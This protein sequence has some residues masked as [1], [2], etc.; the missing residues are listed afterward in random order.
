MEEKLREILNS[1][2][3]SGKVN[4]NYVKDSDIQGKLGF[5][6]NDEDR[7]VA[8]ISLVAELE[9]LGIEV[10]S[11]DVGYY[12]SDITKNYLSEIGKYNV[13]T[14]EEEY[15]LAVRMREGDE[16]ALQEL[17][18]H[19][20]RLV[21]S[22]AKRYI[23]R[24]LDFMDLVQEGNI[25]LL[26]AIKDFDP[27]VGNKLSTYATWW[28]RQFIMRALANTRSLIRMPVHSYDLVMKIKKFSS[29]FSAENG[30]EPTIKE[31]A[32]KFGK[33]E[34]MINSTIL[35]FQNLASLD[36]MVGEDDGY[37]DTCLGDLI[38]DER[39]NISD[40]VEKDELAENIDKILS[41]ILNEREAKVIKARFGLDDSYPKT[42]EL[43]GQDMGITRERVRQIEGKALWKLRISPTTKKLLR[44][45]GDVD[46]LRL[47]AIN[48]SGSIYRKE[49]D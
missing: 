37:N 7:D 20:L 10:E 2:I 43:V 15:A 47:R 41:T 1:L 26:R 21:T 32:D 27:E 3:E 44:E 14:R 24:G 16:E 49:L 4:N 33:T 8:F 6:E 19:N 35:S 9:S 5:I 36:M 40:E 42:L 39:S 38:P 11:K 18:N 17:I 29:S 45:W 48:N 12:N 25:G 23:G 28:I 30:R 34:E 13:L 31:I 22:I 46:T